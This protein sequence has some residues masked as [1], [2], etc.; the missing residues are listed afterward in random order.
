MD[1]TPSENLAQLLVSREGIADLP[2]DVD[3][4]ASRFASI[5]ELDIPL[6]FDGITLKG[7]RREPR[8]ILNRNR[9]ASRR[10]FT[11][12]HELGHILIPWHVG[13]ILDEN[14]Q[15]GET[16]AAYEYHEMEAEANQFAA[17][18][19][20]PTSI[21]SSRIEVF[22]RLK[23]A[24]LEYFVR[25]LAAEAK[26]S[27]IA[28][29][30]RSFRLLP[31]GYIFVVTEDTGVVQYSGRSTGTIPNVPSA[32]NAV[33][34]EKLF[35]GISRRSKI[36]TEDLNFVFY[37]LSH[38]SDSTLSSNTDW[39]SVLTSILAGHFPKESDRKDA[40]RRINAILAA[41]YGS[42]L[43]GQENDYGRFH[44]SLLQRLKGFPDLDWFFEHP[45]FGE[46]F[47]RKASDLFKR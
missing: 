21:V 24:P 23:A 32:G 10:R 47:S 33:Q 38:A 20:L 30:L 46:F 27:L 7:R 1:S 36:E 14:V 34:V 5:R 44:S 16:L 35:D 3:T 37:E 26:A 19:L 31:P 4:V 45:D 9:N 18:L 42:H 40:Y 17:E 41:F 13:V 11:L 6:N 39:K 22:L 8:I 15:R 29:T 2:V 43:K 28:T 12:A 25:K